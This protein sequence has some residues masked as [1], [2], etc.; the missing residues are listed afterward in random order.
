[1]FSFV[2]FFIRVVSKFYMGISKKVKILFLFF[3]NLHF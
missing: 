2:L 3:L 1:M